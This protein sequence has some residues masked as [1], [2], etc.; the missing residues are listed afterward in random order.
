[1]TAVQEQI[2]TGAVKRLEGKVALVTGG[3]RGIGAAIALKLAAE[4][5]RVVLSYAAN[6]EAADKVVSAIKAL[7]S[8]A[9]AVKANVTSASESA[10]VVAETIKA[11]GDV[12]IDILVNNAGVFEMGPI[13]AIDAEQFDRLFDVNVKGVIATTIAAL[14]HMNDGGRIINISSGAADATMTGASLYSATKSALDTLSRIWAQDLGKRQITVNSV[15]PGVTVTDMFKAGIPEEGHQYMIDKTALGRLGQ[16][17][18]IADVVA[19]VASGDARW[20]T[21]QVINVDGG[22]VI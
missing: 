21:G 12:K 20:I 10:A 19:F 17:E 5:A 1:M 13:D 9:V 18:D 22:I 2:K 14:P 15:S 7:G 3:S 6:K 4:G 16:P 11:F 8:K